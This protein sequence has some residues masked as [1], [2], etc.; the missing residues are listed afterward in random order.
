MRVA[1]RVLRELLRELVRD[2]VL[3]PLRLLMDFLSCIYEVLREERFD[4]A[5]AAPTQRLLQPRTR[6][7]RALVPL[8]LNQP[9]LLQPPERV[10]GRCQR[11]REPARNVLRGSGPRTGDFPYGLHVVAYRRGEG[12]MLH[13]LGCIV[14]SRKSTGSKPEG[15]CLLQPLPLPPIRAASPGLSMTA[16]LAGSKTEPWHGQARFWASS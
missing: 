4:W 1:E 15:L 2:G 16:P 3:E 7:R 6:Q 11:D 5:V 14:D 12:L 8:V 13:E 9:H 10:R